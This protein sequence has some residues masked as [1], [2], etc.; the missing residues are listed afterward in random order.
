MAVFA[1]ELLLGSIH[2]EPLRVYVCDSQG[3]MQASETSV[4]VDVERIRKTSI[5]L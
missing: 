3:P 5:L 4:L 2:G 1:S